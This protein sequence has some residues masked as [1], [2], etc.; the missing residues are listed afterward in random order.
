VSDTLPLAGVRV[1]DL[2]SLYAA[3]CAAMLLGDYGADVIKVEHP[4]GDPM[5]RLG[6][7]KGDVPLW[8]KMIGRNKR[9]VSL[10]LSRPE[11]RDVLLDLAATADILIENFRPGRL[12][13]WGLDYD[14]LSAR[15]EGLIVLR[16]T[17]FGQTGPYAQQA[18]FGT[19]AECM[20][21]WVYASGEEGDPPML[22][23][24]GLADP[25][26][27]LT[28]AFACLTALHH[29]GV[30]GK[31]QVIDATLA[32][33]MLFLTGPSITYYDQLGEIAE[34]VGNRSRQS[35]P[36]NVYRSRD[37][38]WIAVSTSAQSVAERVVALVGHPEMTREPWFATAA[39]R[40]EH[41]DELDAVVGAWIGAHDAADV[42]S[43]FNAAN[44]A[45]SPILDTAEVLQDPQY[46][47]RESVA[48]VDDPE[49][50]PVLMPNMLFRLSA[51]GGRIDFTGRAHGA[52]TDE[53]L[54]K[55]LGYDAR[56]LAELRAAGIV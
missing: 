15:N 12:D 20:S 8:W 16:L 48:T 2:A 14:T 23:P 41:A 56:R 29:R 7:R 28:G 37:G 55:E 51:S 36:R 52:D 22:P 35:A 43:Q 4:N 3:P 31:G 10:D 9:C 5:R 39:Q 33:P 46:V 49:L 30:T 6:K 26:A 32:E 53:I 18:A 21:G 45:A 24:F 34:R 27:G 47:A 25:L 38:Q 50:G 44:A 1:L 11:G 54:T 13:Q 17:G 42:I 40:V 19:Q